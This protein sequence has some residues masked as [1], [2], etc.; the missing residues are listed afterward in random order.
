M[1]VHNF[2]G[3]ATPP[4]SQTA[5]NDVSL[6]LIW[7]TLEA[8]TITGIRFWQPSGHSGTRTV[9]LYNVDTTSLMASK[10]ASSVS[11]GWNEVL[12]DT[13]QSVSIGVTYCAVL[14]ST[15]SDYGYQGS[16]SWPATSNGGDLYTASTNAGRFDYS[17]SLAR[18]TTVTGTNF[19]VDI[20]FDDGQSS[21][22]TGSG[23]LTLANVTSA[24]T[25]SV[26]GVVAGS[27]A[28]TLANV[29]AQGTATAPWVGRYAAQIAGD[30]PVLWYRLGSETFP[31]A[32]NS[33]TV[34]GDAT[35]YYDA[36]TPS[37]YTYDPQSYTAPLQNM[38][39]DKCTWFA[40]NTYSAGA[41]VSALF[42]GKYADDFGI[43]SASGCTLEC[44]LIR[45][46]SND[47]RQG[48]MGLGGGSFDG[49]ESGSDRRGLLFNSLSSLAVGNFTTY[50]LHTYSGNS[51]PTWTKASSNGVWAY[52]AIVY[53]PDGGTN[54][55]G[56]IRV[57]HLLAS[58]GW[59]TTPTLT[60]DLA[61][62]L[63]FR[64]Q[65]AGHGTNL[66]ESSFCVGRLNTEML[67]RDNL[68]DEVAVYDRPL[69]ITEIASHFRMGTL[70]GYI[71]AE[72]AITLDNV[73][74]A[75]QGKIVVVGQEAI[76]TGTVTASG[77]GVVVVVGSA[78]PTLGTVT[79]VGAGTASANSVSGSGA[80]TLANVSAIGSGVVVLRGS[81]SLTLANVTALGAA[82]FGSAEDID[83][84]SSRT[85]LFARASRS[86]T[87]AAEARLATIG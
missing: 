83:T 43:D 28:L 31:I 39:G 67:G 74:A 24:G 64:K 61:G 51:H 4:S 78:A 9:A 55:Y 27:A 41:G 19:F 76:S 15:G 45:S 36:G 56:E 57:H 2:F 72:G 47:A 81:G 53:D 87:V 73:T 77:Q 79:A 29:S 85:A 23:A 12:F 10:V 49:G 52:C 26:V 13:P 5:D 32:A 3:T 14:H 33:G 82:V 42:S 80:L 37:G 50:E 48:L 63:T 17:S 11:N 34:S 71:P 62:P 46:A 60:H 25:G 35:L 44:W 16:Y 59:T 1:T 68:M 84:P 66:Q 86:A 21:T 7:A 30:M 69:T 18:P 38:G 75:G 54:G 22:V 65:T 6:G 8:G 58:E 40:P 20:L 70:S